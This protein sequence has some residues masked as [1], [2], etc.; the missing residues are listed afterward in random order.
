[1]NIYNILQNRIAEL[2][3]SLKNPKTINPAKSV[4]LKTMRDLSERNWSA[5]WL[6]NLEHIL[7]TDIFSERDGVITNAE[8]LELAQL[9]EKAGG[10]WVWDGNVNMPTFVS[11]FEWEDMLTDYRRQQE[12]E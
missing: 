10:W 5:G 2:H 12:V 8:K 7:W 1:M 3:D 6:C 11:L 4:L 9:A